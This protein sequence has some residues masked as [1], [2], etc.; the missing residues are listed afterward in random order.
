V[1]FVIG[2]LTTTFEPTFKVEVTSISPLSILTMDLTRD[3][4]SPVPGVI[5]D[6]CAKGVKSLVLIY[7]GDMPCPESVIVKLMYVVTVDCGDG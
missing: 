1:G 6:S 7:S 2:S 3:N 4:P 5:E